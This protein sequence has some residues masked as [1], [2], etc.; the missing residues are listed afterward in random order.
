VTTHSFEVEAHENFSAAESALALTTIMES[1]LGPDFAR[2]NEIIERMAVAA[3]ALPEG[4][5]VEN[6]A[7]LLGLLG[8]EPQR[9]VLDDIAFTG[10]RSDATD[11]EQQAAWITRVFHDARPAHLATLCEAAADRF[12]RYI[13]LDIPAALD[14]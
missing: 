4:D 11:D 3:H 5:F 9:A 10:A 2:T 6:M 8:T 12:S 14:A 7:T 13:G 1:T